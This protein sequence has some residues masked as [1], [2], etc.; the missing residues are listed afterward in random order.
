MSFDNPSDHYYP[1]VDTSWR[2][3]REYVLFALVVVLSLLASEKACAAPSGF[4]FCSG[5]GEACD[6]R[7]VDAW[8]TFGAGE[9]SCDVTAGTCS[10]SYSPVI[11]TGGGEFYVVCRQELFTGPDPAPGLPKSCFWSAVG[12]PSPGG[13]A[14]SP[15]SSTSTDPFHLSAE[16]GAVVAAF[17]FTVWG[18]AYAWRA[19]IRSLDAAD[20]TD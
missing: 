18:A 12:A 1:P 17:I 19:A 2:C 10:G 20:G 4:S 13:G 6:L 14:S 9:G 16:D 3:I 5:E 15:S 11:R 7:G 8:V